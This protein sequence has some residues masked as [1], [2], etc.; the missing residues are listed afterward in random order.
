MTLE[1]LHHQGNLIG[2]AMSCDGWREAIS[3]DPMGRVIRT[4][5]PSVERVVPR[6]QGYLSRR[7]AWSKDRG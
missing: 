1:V 3:V 2:F 5:T 6:I 4:T 7:P